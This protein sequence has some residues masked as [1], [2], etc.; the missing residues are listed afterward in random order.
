MIYEAPAMS[1]RIVLFNPSVPSVAFCIYQPL[2]GFLTR[3]PET[4]VCRAGFMVHGWGYA[5]S[6]ADMNTR[7][8][9]D[10]WLPLRKFEFAC[11]AETCMSAIERGDMDVAALINW[12]TNVH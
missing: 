5:V 4:E 9:N 11:E 10:C 12:V 1:D 7:L 3:F 2:R 6:P 8:S